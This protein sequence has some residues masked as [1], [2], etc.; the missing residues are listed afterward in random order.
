MTLC[1]TEITS[2]GVLYYA[3]PVLSGRISADTGWSATALMAAF[4]G[5]LVVSG[6][7]GIAVGRWLDRHGPRWL[8][9]AGSLLGAFSVVGIALAPSLTV[10][11]LA[12]VVA[13]VAMSAVL[14]APAF[15]ALTRWYGDQRVRALTVL[16]LVAGLASTVFAPLTAALEAE[17]GWRHTYLV[18]AAVARRG[19]GAGSS[20]RPA[21]PVAT[22]DYDAVSTRCGRW[23][24]FVAGRFS[25]WCSPWCW[26][27]AQR[28]PC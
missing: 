14:Y 12:W 11:V 20:G 23:P 28:T 4:S 17:L 19:H 13:G 3:F 27:P 15:A 1:L 22:I 26:R 6:L 10:F 16:T 8:M 25:A 2:W 7:L 18:L 5:G 24:S 9:S 21:T